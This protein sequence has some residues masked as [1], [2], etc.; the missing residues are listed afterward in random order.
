MA[1]VPVRWWL[2]AAGACAL[3]AGLLVVPASA[4]PAELPPE[5]VTIVMQA[6]QPDGTVLRE[7][8]EFCGNRPGGDSAL[9]D[10][11]AGKVFTLDGAAQIGR[12]CG[13]R[14]DPCVIFGP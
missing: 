12:D 3:I 2:P 9:H 10:W 4:A 13:T 8:L 6:V 1:G 7:H 5:C 11:V 14:S